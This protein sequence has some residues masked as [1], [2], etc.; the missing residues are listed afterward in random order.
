VIV[1]AA[2]PPTL[3]LYVAV[4]DGNDRPLAGLTTADFVVRVGDAEEPVTSVKLATGPISLVFM[5]NTAIE[6]VPSV[7]RAFQSGIGS[8]ATRNPGAQVSVLSWNRPPIF[9]D[10]GAQA[11]NPDPLDG[12]LAGGR[13]LTFATA[14]A[15]EALKAAPGRHVVLQLTK[16]AAF[17]TDA[18]TSAV[19]VSP[20]TDWI[21]TLRAAKSSFWVVD[22]GP[23][24]SGDPNE[25]NLDNAA[26]SSGGWILRITDDSSA[27]QSAVDRRVD[28]LLSQY[29]VSVQASSSQAAGTIRVAVT[30]AGAKASTAEYPQG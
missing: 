3:D 11:T 5:N 21:A 13:S 19:T 7:R 22:I 4:T 27:L 8:L 1:F 2:G 30:R 28:I 15:M 18:A 20:N 10:A 6:N 17:P 24:M 12:A 16:H 25:P 14:R 29:V 23:I 26:R 9:A